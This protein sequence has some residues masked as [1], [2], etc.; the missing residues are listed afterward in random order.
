MIALRDIQ[1]G[2]RHSSASI[3]EISTISGDLAELS[4]DL[5]IL[6]SKFDVGQRE[7][8]EGH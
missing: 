4:D 6:V 5:K 8:L 2:T 3:L 1:D 7:T